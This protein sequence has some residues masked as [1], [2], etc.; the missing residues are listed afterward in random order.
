[1]LVGAQVATGL[2]AVLL[3]GY[4]VR[5]QSAELVR[6]SLELRLDRVAEEVEARAA[7]DEEGRLSFPRR[8]QLDLP[9]RFPDPV[10]VLDLDGRVVQGPEGEQPGRLPPEAQ[11]ALDEGRVAVA[12]DGAEGSWALAPLLAP[13][14]L[15][16][17]ALYVRPLD[18]TLDEMLAAPRDAFQRTL[19]L[20]AALALASALLLGAFLTWRLV[21]PLR[22][23]TRR[24]EALGA[25][26]YADRLPEEGHDELGRLAAAINE[27][28]DR[29]EAAL[30]TL[31][32]TD[33]M[34]REL[35]ANVGHDL[36][37][38]LAALQGYLEEAGRFAAEGRKEEAIE[39]LTVARRQSEQVGGL[40]AD[41]FEL[42]KLE[43]AAQADASGGAGPLQRGPVPLG[44]LLH[45]AARAHRRA[46]E[47]AGV[48][49]EVYLAPALPV[50]D[51]D[52]ARLLR[53]LDNLL[54]NALRHTL[55]GGTVR[56]EA[57]AN[58][59]A[60]VVRVSDTGEGIA[61]EVLDTVF[62]RY[63]RGASARTRGVDGGTGLGLAIARAIARAHGGDLTAESAAGEGSTFTF[64]LP[65]RATEKK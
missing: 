6:S 58:E 29:V 3:S 57:E 16:A 19:W 14:G 63:Y 52:G 20:V 33:R 11:A 24:V 60:V 13:D 15:P 43:M 31:R 51:A 10:Y 48:G 47:A 59:R 40:V 41:L 49:L 50:L 32:A 23:M 21:R 34:R 18:R 45:D 7:F 27:M 5:T 61:P 17:G 2:V 44:E 25:E 26:D 1:M 42:S 35:V 53:L 9:T 55:E 38:P 37:T 64:T 28:A 36:R 56:L 62:E 4:F 54:S 39:A 22:R 12:S 8:L 30:A 65:L 46:F